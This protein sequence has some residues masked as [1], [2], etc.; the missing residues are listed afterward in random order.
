VPLVE[1]ERD[2]G[3]LVFDGTREQQLHRV[4][5]TMAETIVEA[6]LYRAK[7][8]SGGRFSGG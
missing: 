6:A 4:G 7:R 3:V 8:S 5:P 1:R 2:D